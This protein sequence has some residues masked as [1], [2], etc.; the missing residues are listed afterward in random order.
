MCGVQKIAA[1]DTVDQKG[2]NLMQGPPK[3]KQLPKSQAELVLAEMATYV[4]NI[5][6]V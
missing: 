1:H 3:R 4:N 5:L 2:H 6:P